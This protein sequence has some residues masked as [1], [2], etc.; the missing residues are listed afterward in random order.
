[1]SSSTEIPQDRPNP[2]DKVAAV[3]PAEQEQQPPMP[4]D[5]EVA[6]ACLN[7]RQE[8]SKNSS[9]GG[10][11]SAQG[12][13]QNDNDHDHRDNGP[14]QSPNQQDP[15]S[16]GMPMPMMHPAMPPIPG[17]A[18][19]RGGPGGRE[20]DDGRPPP[21]GG[22]PPHMYGGYMPHPHLMEYGPN[23]GGPPM[24]PPNGGPSY[25]QNMGN[26]NS[27]APG[28]GG[29]YPHP[30]YHPHDAE[31]YHH[32]MNMGGDMHYGMPGGNDPNGGMMPHPGG[33]FYAPMMHPDAAGHYHMMGNYPHGGGGGGYMK[34]PHPD[35]M[36]PYGNE[37]K[38]MRAGEGRGDEEAERR[39]TM[40]KHI[41][42]N[43]Q[44]MDS[45]KMPEKHK[46]GKRSTDM[47]RRPLSAYNFFFSEERERILAALPDPDEA[48]V[49]RDEITKTEGEE[50]SNEGKDES[51]KEEEKPLTYQ[52]KLT[53]EEMK[54]KVESRS[55]RLL[56]LREQ[57]S[58]KRR[59]HRK[60]HGKIGFK[61]LVKQIGERWRSLPASEKEYYTELAKTDL[62]RYKEQMSEYNTKNGGVTEKLANLGA[63]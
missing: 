27:G 1:M 39:N 49:K 54:E 15:R 20:D 12:Q 2:G 17:G 3:N 45:K 30:Y 18:E 8:S 31:G 62:K 55:K 22:M 58:S 5:L 42:D 50:N 29:Y 16:G 34:R 24:P 21:M 35:D 61:E 11:G 51:V 23:N 63:M 26:D 9:G 44:M 56:A 57:S 47:P 46:K 33:H 59:P 28:P 10:G 7:L 52:E 41:E 48:G 25:Y 19:G 53:V 37:S 32:M 40:I 38:R 43:S 14:H 13:P 4:H 60:T 36:P 6:Q